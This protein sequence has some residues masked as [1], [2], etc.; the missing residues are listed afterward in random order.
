M[1]ALLAPARKWTQ[2]AASPSVD[3]PLPGILDFAW[4]KAQLSSA[5]EPT[6]FNRGRTGLTSTS[7]ER[8]SDERPGERAFAAWLMTSM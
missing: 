2:A 8:W 6:W 3:F 4:V 7:G 5:G 1:V